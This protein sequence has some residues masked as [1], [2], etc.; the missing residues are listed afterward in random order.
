MNGFQTSGLSDVHA[1]EDDYRTSHLTKGA[2]YDNDLSRDPFDSYMTT[3]ERRLLVRL[4]AKLFPKGLE[5]YLDF[6]CGTGRI[7]EIIEPLARESWGVDVSPAMLEQ[8]TLKC[9]RTQ[10]RIG[11]LTRED[12][13]IPPAD[14]VTAFRF[15]ANA[16]NELRRAALGA[17]RDRLKKGGYLIVNNHRNAWSV[18]NL[19]TSHGPERIDLHYGKLRGLLTDAG[20]RVRRTFGIGF[21]YVRYK[22]NRVE[23]VRSAVVQMIEPLSLIRPVAFFCPDIV[24]LAQ[25]I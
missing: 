18:R 5:T 22:L 7:T 16:Q 1:P 19:L 15:L 4:V 14:L 10:F 2:D 24:V 9:S 3:V 17:M 8:A 6:A 21:W 20:F 25:R 12:L 13:P 23:V 11:D